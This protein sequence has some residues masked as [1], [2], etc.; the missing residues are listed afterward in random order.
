MSL[1]Q[2]ISRFPKAPTPSQAQALQFLQEKG[3]PTKKDE[4]WKYTS[5]K[6]WVEKSYVWAHS[7]GLKPNLES[8]LPQRA[9]FVNGCFKPELSKLPAGVSFETSL[10]KN[11]PEDAFEAL[12]ATIADQV[13]VLKFAPRTQLEKPFEV[14]WIALGKQETSFFASTLRIEVGAE[15]SVT[16]LERSVQQDQ[17]ES[18]TTLQTELH[19]GS[20]A[21]AEYVQIQDYNL[22]SFHYSKTQIELAEN[23][24]FTSLVVA[25]GALQSRSEFEV[26][27][28]GS[29]AEARTLGLYALSESQ[30]SDHYTR[31]RHHVGGS[32]SDQVYKGVLD[33][34]SRGVFNG[35]V[36]I[37][38]DAQ[39]GNSEQLNMNLLLSPQAEINSKPE[40]KIF[41][42]DVKA[43]HG[44]T[45]GQLQSE[46]LFYLQ[47]RGIKRGPATQ[48]LAQAFV[49]DL[50]ERLENAE[51]RTRV[52]QSLVQKLAQFEGIRNL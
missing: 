51:L 28:R 5:L 16:L 17:L 8:S 34:K 12:S 33:G 3:F 37:A 23:S 49:M 48:L 47:S 15:S 18:F 27:I 24:N 41:A 14:L 43:S 2:S 46:E 38:Q 29:G 1:V 40:L 9:V 25:L 50:V 22:R 42:D 13:N 44:S 31:I 19:L 45:I 7:E 30:Q 52:S 26:N 36:Y 4:N 6:S 10:R 21:K 35:H 20:R 11:H 39:K 32:H